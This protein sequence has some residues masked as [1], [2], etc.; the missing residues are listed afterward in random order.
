MTAE[1]CAVCE[2]RPT[3]DGWACAGCTARAGAHLTEII[4][5]APDARLVAAGLVRRGRGGSG[6]KPGSRP[7]LN[8]GATDVVD[9]VQNA[10]T[11]LARDIAETRGAQFVS[12][13]FAG[14]RA[15]DP[16][17][18]AA[19]W[20]GGQLEWLRHAVDE[21]GQA[22]AVQAFDEIGQS[23][24]R[25]RGLVNG[26]AEQRY[27]GPCG[28]AVAW[29]DDGTEVERDEP[30]AGDVFAP[31][32]ADKG[33]CRACKARWATAERRAW[34]DDEVRSWAFRPSEIDDAYGVSQDTIRSWARRTNRQTGEF[35]LASFW[36]T[37]S[38]LVT[39]WEPTDDP[40][41]IR[42]RGPRLHYVGDVL[43]LAAADAARRAGEQAKRARRKET[44][45]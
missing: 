36:R 42:A 34:L 38:G 30:C 41:E 23:A 39:P 27:L 11:T 15:A 35:L 29:D 40:D 44:A 17:A 22:Y 28:S 26:P 31:L 19:K 10:L 1:I 18:E 5:L 7:P 14:H 20:L 9:A 8:D 25:L 16:L 24:G 32:G 21:Q 43:D 6:G 3:P 4:E 12:T 45:A 2:K 13:A 33:T 37:A